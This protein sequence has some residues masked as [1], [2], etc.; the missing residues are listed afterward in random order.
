MIKELTKIQMMERA[1]RKRRV[2]LARGLATPK[3]TKPRHYE[4]VGEPIFKPAP[5][6]S[7]N[8]GRLESFLQLLGWRPKIPTL[9]P[10]AEPK[11]E[12]K[13]IYKQ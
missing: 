2:M 9:H 6:P 5:M 1:N 13:G 11:I 3:G 4:P 10:K 8:L 12:P 7:L